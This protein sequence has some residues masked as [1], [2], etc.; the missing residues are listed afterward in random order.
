MYMYKA[1]IYTKLRNLRDF[2]K[3]IL[4]KFYLIKEVGFFIIFLLLT[5]EILSRG[6]PSITKFEGKTER[7]LL[8][9]LHT[10]LPPTL[11]P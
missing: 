5:L 8:T 3:I 11:Q 6:A 7:H 9:L 4:I 1:H 10:H 2:L